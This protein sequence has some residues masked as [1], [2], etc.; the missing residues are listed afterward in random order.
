[1]L[2]SLVFDDMDSLTIN[3]TMLNYE[4]SVLN[5]GLRINRNLTWIEQ[6]NHV[7][8]KVFQCLYQF[9]KLCFD[10]PTFIR[11]N[12]VLS[13]IMP[14]FDYA[15]SA[16]CDLNNELTNKLQKAQN[17]CIRYIF[18]LRLDDHV[19]PY[20]KELKWLKIN[21]RREFNVLTLA[22]KVIKY[23]TPEYLHE[24]YVTMDNV[25]LRNTRFG[26]NVLQ[27]PIHRT[28]IYTKS[29]HVM[30]I[31]LLNGLETNIKESENEKSFSRKLKIKLLERYNV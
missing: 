9:K 11:K 27:F 14:Y 4:S 21:E 6:V 25:H 10:P 13:L 17:A 8:N 3:G 22:Y 26:A 18:K 20:Y 16:Y 5:L 29:F 12:L 31:R 1:M 19:T 2:N 7:H 28:V 15:I 30:S 24:N 23:K